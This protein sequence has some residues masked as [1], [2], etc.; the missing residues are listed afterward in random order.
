[1]NNELSNKVKRNEDMQDLYEENC[2][3]FL[4]GIKQD[5]LFQLPRAAITKYCRPG[6]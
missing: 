5:V 4:K 6:G 3:P 2:S 1:M